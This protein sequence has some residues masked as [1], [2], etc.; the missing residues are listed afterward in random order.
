M[1][2]LQLRY[3]AL[4]ESAFVPQIQF[5]HLQWFSVEFQYAM[6]YYK[7]FFFI[8]LMKWFHTNNTMKILW[9][10]CVFFY[11]FQSSPCVW[12]DEVMCRV[13]GN[14]NQAIERAGI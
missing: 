3:M 5:I 12:G 10:A 9:I 4:L 6:N 2:F 1:V 8:F 7:T 11:S 13:D 14:N